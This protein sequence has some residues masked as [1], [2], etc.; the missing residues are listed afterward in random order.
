MG[1]LHSIATNQAAILALFRVVT[2]C[3]SNQL[4]TP[5]VFQ[6][7]PALVIHN[8]EAGTEMTFMR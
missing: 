3:V 2:R 8:G 7:Y 5:G 6:D 1:K 4:P